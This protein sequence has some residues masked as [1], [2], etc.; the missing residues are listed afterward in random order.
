MNS[1]VFFRNPDVPGLW[2]ANGFTETVVIFRSLPAAPVCDESMKA[3]GS[4]N[5]RTFEGWLNAHGA[6]TVRLRGRAGKAAC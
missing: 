2:P 1:L 6:G 3:Y 4:S 5:V